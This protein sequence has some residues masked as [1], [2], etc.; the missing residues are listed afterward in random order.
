[1]PRVSRKKRQSAKK[2]INNLNKNK[3]C[4]KLTNQE[5]PSAIQKSREENL[6][7]FLLNINRNGWHRLQCTE[8]YNGTFLIKNLN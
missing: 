5:S 4:F 8:D 2:N 1:M 6:K 7:K 3:Q